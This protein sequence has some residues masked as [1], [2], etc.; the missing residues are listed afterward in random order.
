MFAP[1]IAKPQTKVAD[2][3]TRKLVPQPSTL[4]A[5]PLGVGA[6]EQAW[7]LQGTIGNQA[8]LRYLTQ[9]LS[10]LPDKGPAE[11]HEQEATSKNMAT[12]EAPR[13]PSWDFSKI[14]VFP[15][16]RADRTQP[17]SPLAATPLLSAIQAKLAVGRVNDPLEHEAVRVP[18]VLG[19]MQSA[20][21]EDGGA[22]MPTPA[23]LARAGASTRLRDDSQADRT[24][25]LLGAN[26]VAWGEEVRFRQGRLT[27]HTEVGQA[28]IAHEIVHVA[29]QRE[30]GRIRAQRMVSVDVLKAGVSQ[31]MAEAMTDAELVQQMN[32]LRAYLKDNSDDAAQANLTTLEGVAYERQ[33]TAYNEPA[34]QQAAPPRPTSADPTPTMTSPQR[35]IEAYHRAKIAPAFRAKLESLVSLESLAG[36]LIGFAVGFAIAQ[37]TPVGWAADVGLLLTGVFIGTSV[38]AV[39]KHLVAFAGAANAQTSAEL[40]MAGAE[41]A[42][43]VAEGSVDLVIGLLTHKLGGGKGEPEGAPVPEASQVRIGVR[44]NE[45]VLVPAWTVPADVVAAM[46]ASA[47]AGVKGAAI[48]GP[49]MAV[50][51]GPGGPKL[52]APSSGSPGVSGAEPGA[53]R[54]AEESYIAKL[55][56]R[57]PKLGPVNIGTKQRPSGSS[58]I[59]PAEDVTPEVGGK[60]EYRTKVSGAPESAFEER[61]HTS[62]GQFSLTI[63]DKGVAMEL[64]G[65]SVDGWIDN[66][67][68]EQKLDKVDDIVVRLRVEADWAEHYGLKGVHYSIAPPSVADAVEAELAEQGVRSV[69]RIE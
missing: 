8:M 17:L 44:G 14:P 60:Q 19:A 23:A 38:V 47:V 49:L 24:A 52:P 68:I 40:D 69:Y 41:F 58:Y 31:D 59:G 15:S 34:P 26:A 56:Q 57:F 48:A 54:A 16:D 28:L 25:R 36:M 1:K 42:A 61:M 33:G 4:V 20:V 51:G 18:G 46:Q 22:A 11:Q 6:V 21:A 45:L 64:D 5:R 27:P 53:A 3:S 9:R 37:L 12:Q 30:T 32:I 65:I 66:V 62:Q 7:M 39:A 67:K 10:N 50:A 2:S 29:R 43:A 63:I 35:V 55:K 13:G